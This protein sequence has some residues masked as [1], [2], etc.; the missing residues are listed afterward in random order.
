MRQPYPLS[1]PEFYLQSL[2][3]CQSLFCDNQVCEEKDGSPVILLSFYT[4]EKWM[5]VWFRLSCKHDYEALRKN[6]RPARPQVVP[7]APGASICF[8]SIDGSLCLWFYSDPRFS[9]VQFSPSVMFDSLRPHGLQHS[10]PPCPSRT[11]GV[12]SD[13][14]PLSWWCHPLNFCLGNILLFLAKRSFTSLNRFIPRYL[15]L[16]MVF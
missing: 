15:M 8:H 4:R 12:Y 1:C 10:R 11:P 14:C 7:R 13:S 2:E 3:G 16:L 9:S 5:S 6:E